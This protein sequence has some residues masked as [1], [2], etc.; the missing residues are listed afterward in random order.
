MANGLTTNQC[1]T[2]MHKA[3][4]MI[5]SE[6][7]CL[8]RILS[9]MLPRQKFNVFE[10][11]ETDDLIRTVQEGT[12]DLIMIASSSKG[13]ND[14]LQLVREIR[15]YEPEIPIILI[16]TVSSEELAIEAFRGGVSDFLKM[17]IE[18]E[19]LIIS[20]KRN[21]PSPGS[22]SSPTPEPVRLDPVGGDKLVTRSPAMVGMIN[23]LKKAAMADCN[24]LIT[25]ET[26]TGKE[27]VAN[28]IHQYSP[29]AKNPL[30]IINCAAI[31][32]TLIESELFGYEKGAFTGAFARKE[33]ALRKADSGTIVFDEI[34]DMSPQAQAKVLRIM[35]TKEIC[36]VGGTQAVPFNVRFIA[37]TNKDPEQL[38]KED[39]FR[40]DLYFRLNVARIYLPPLRERK[41]DILLL[42]EYFRQKFNRKIG[43]KVKGFTPEVVKAL[44]NYNWP[45][46]VRELKNRLEAAFLGA[47]QQI[48]I[49]NFPEF[50]RN[51]LQQNK[52]LSQDERSRLIATLLSTRWNKTKAA[53][54][55]NWSRVTLY[56]KMEKYGIAQLL[57]DESVADTLGTN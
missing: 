38:M 5:I 35:E 20:I 32:D 8:R 54:Q 37:A 23:F 50:F 15:S 1:E 22:T 21:L 44:V 40:S 10:S 48:V 41:E 24:V 45:G 13:A 12:A 56:R 18:S 19:D 47:D 7:E 4:I 26:G 33:G 49:E 52:E 3:G 11:S 14:G 46:N 25:G 57:K 9:R 39:K 28:L 29:R 6:D 51:Q 2:V 42:L 16:T 17:P 34:G 55:L 36:R 30:V 31:P 53:Q 43:K 27:L